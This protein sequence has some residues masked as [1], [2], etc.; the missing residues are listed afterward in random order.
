MRDEIATDEER[1]TGMIDRLAMLRGWSPATRAAYRADL[2]DAA[3]VLARRGASLFTAGDAEVRGYLAELGRRGLSAA[4]IRRR[5]SALST[6]FSFLQE[7][8]LREDHPARRLP[9]MRA[10]RRL[11]RY[12]S[13]EE[14]ERLLAAPDV[15]TRAGLRDRCMLELMYATGLRVSEIAGLTLAG[16]DMAA[17]FVRVTGKG[18]RERIVPFGEE[19]GRWLSRWLER[20][21]SGSAFLFPGRGGRP[22]TRQNIWQRIRMHARAAGIRPLPSPHTLRHA[23]ATHLLNHGAD[24]R[25]VQMLLGHAHVTTTEIYT[26]VTRARLR[27]AVERNHPLGRAA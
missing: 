6:W 26:H 2:L 18:G 1:L 21:P 7:S 8:G 24:L 15:R 3:R 23:F 17:G 19:A 14:V 13:E 22:M 10:G 27:E 11:P 4:T 12:M 20:R 25:A 9:G 5:R 16:L